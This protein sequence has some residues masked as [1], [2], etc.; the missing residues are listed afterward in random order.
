MH[1]PQGRARRGW[2]GRERSRRRPA[3]AER[4]QR[5]PGRSRR[6]G[7]R[8]T[9]KVG[10]SVTLGELDGVGRLV[11]RRRAVCAD[12]RALLARDRAEEGLAVHEGR[13]AASEGRTSARRAT[14]R[15]SSQSRNEEAE[16]AR[17][18]V[19]EDGSVFRAERVGVGAAVCVRVQGRVSRRVEETRQRESATG[20]TAL[21]LDLGA[22]SGRRRTRVRDHRLG[23]LERQDLDVARRDD[24]SCEREMQGQV[25]CRGE[26][27]HRGED[28]AGR[29]RV[30]AQD[31]RLHDLLH[32]R[33][34]RDLLGGSKEVRPR[35][36][37]HDLEP[38]LARVDARV[39][40]D[41]VAR[42]VD[43]ALGF[44]LLRGALERVSWTARGLNDTWTRASEV[45][46]ERERGG[47]T[48][49]LL[50]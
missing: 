14:A 35:A 34:H 4:S 9:H 47:R 42:Q 11:P 30:V 25:R 48:A 15:S 21:L 2:A 6:K 28:R 29:T 44:L 38:V 22:P 46:R 39:G 27:R 3:G 18:H 40:D 33:A 13:A 17:R 8:E 1:R 41:P 5:R 49:S 50:R 43:D 16:D 20:R 36:V 7:G 26:G 45:E 23:G 31:G 37:V 19:H 32:P 24:R 10:R 12:R